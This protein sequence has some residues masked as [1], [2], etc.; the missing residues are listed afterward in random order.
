MDAKQIARIAKSLGAFYESGS[1]R[2]PTVW[3]KEEF[4]R[5]IKAAQ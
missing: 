5:R 1:W 4:L 2:F 3:A